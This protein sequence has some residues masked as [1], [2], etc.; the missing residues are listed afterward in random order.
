MPHGHLNHVC[1]LSRDRVKGSIV[2]HSPHLSCNGI[3]QG[4]IA[5]Y[6]THKQQRK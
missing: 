6:T 3:L 4:Q 2:V 5:L 1:L